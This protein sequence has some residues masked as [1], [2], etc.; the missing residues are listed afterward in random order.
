MAVLG[1]NINERIGL[2]EE[3]GFLIPDLTPAARP[4]TSLGKYGKIRKTYLKERRT[5]LWNRLILSEELCPHLR[6][7]QQAGR[8]GKNHPPL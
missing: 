3:R 4:E 1:L 6:Q 2:Y 7:P 5:L 8:N